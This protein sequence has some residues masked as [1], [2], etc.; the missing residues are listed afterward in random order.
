MNAFWERVTAVGPPPSTAVV[1]SVVVAAALLVLEPNAWR[2]SRGVVTIAHE[3]AHL[4]LALLT[5]RRLHGVR[6]HADTSGVAIS[7]GKPTGIG[8]VLMTAA[9]YVG[10]SLLGLAAALT[11]NTGHIVAV[12]WTAVA[13]CALMLVLVR[14]V[15]G[16]FSLVVTGGALGAVGWR[17][18]DQAQIAVAYLIAI[19]LLMA[20]PRPVLELRR[21][22][23]RTSDPDQLARLTVFPAAVWTGFFLVVTVGAL[24]A[25]AG[26]LNPF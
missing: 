6:L 12:L 4:L 16:A 2:R 25:G 24:V 3:G 9:G 17:A 1:V 14:N 20:G 15:Y 26:L 10:P 8:V 21:R 11:L 7:S 5:G 23:S 19:F 18:P 22:R 13:V